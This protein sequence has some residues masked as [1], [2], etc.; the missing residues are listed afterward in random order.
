MEHIGLRFFF[1][2]VENLGIEFAK[3]IDEASR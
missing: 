3:R 2:E 1:V